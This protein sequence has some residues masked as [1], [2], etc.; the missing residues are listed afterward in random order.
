[1][2]S[3]GLFGDAEKPSAKIQL[4]TPKKKVEIT[5][6]E[7]KPKA[8]KK[9]EEVKKVEKRENRVASGNVQELSDEER[10]E[11]FPRGPVSLKQLKLE[12]C[13]KR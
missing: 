1:M 5:L 13:K 12:K 4:S 11:R 7:F 9:V 8:E 10:K 2:K 3:L 6:S